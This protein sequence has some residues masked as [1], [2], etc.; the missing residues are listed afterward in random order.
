MKVSASQ[1]FH[2]DSKVRHRHTNASRYA[3]SVSLSVI[4]AGTQALL[5]RTASSTASQTSSG[6]IIRSGIVP[7]P[8]AMQR[9]HCSGG[10][11]ETC[12]ASLQRKQCASLLQQKQR[13]QRRATSNNKQASHWL[14]DLLL[15]TGVRSRHLGVHEGLQKG[16]DS[17]ISDRSCW[18]AR[19]AMFTGLRRRPNA[20]VPD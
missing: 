17:C 10:G 9:I 19:Q 20:A 7:A 12:T 5:V 6:E 14:N 15:L 11:P 4:S 13:R 3:F 2:T 8:H 1:I 16:V 18:R